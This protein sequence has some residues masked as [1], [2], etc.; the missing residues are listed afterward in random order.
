MVAELRIGTLGAAKITPMALTRPAKNVE[1]VAVTAVAARDRKRA[2][3]FAKSHGIAKVHDDYD[4]L[5]ADRDLDAIYNPLP[6][7]LHAEWTLRALDAGKHVLCEKPFASNAE[8]AE[9]VHQASEQ[10]GLVVMEAFHYRYHPMIQRV[11]ALVAS[12]ELGSLRRVETWMCFPLPFKNDIRYQLDLAGGATMDAGC[13]SIHMARTITGEEP[14]VLSSRPK[15]VSPEIDG[16]MDANLRFPSGA[17]G[18][19]HCSMWSRRIAKIAAAVILEGGEIRA[20]NPVVPQLFHGLKWRKNG[21]RWTKEKF[22]K[23]PTYEYQLEAFRD[24]VIA[25]KPFPTTTRD[26]VKNM[27]VIDAVY[28]AAGMSTRG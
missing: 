23:K 16:A 27:R 10:S 1:D 7:S 14:E 6:N 12:G 11:R 8:E 15:L 13:Y 19:I 25:G 4:T 28:R 26:A 2:E 20:L 22:G 9:R 3:S 24:A 5:L 17:E 18:T 21:G